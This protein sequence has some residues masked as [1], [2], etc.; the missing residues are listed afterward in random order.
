MDPIIRVMFR[1][2]PGELQRNYVHSLKKFAMDGDSAGPVIQLYTKLVTLDCKEKIISLSR[3]R[4]FYEFPSRS[5]TRMW[6]DIASDTP[7]ICTSL[8]SLKCIT[9][10]DAYYNAILSEINP[11]SG[12]HKRFRCPWTARFVIPFN[13]IAP[14][15][16]VV[17][18]AFLI[19]PACSGL[20]KIRL[21]TNFERAIVY[22][23][24]RQVY[25]ICSDG[26]L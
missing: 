17:I 12:R 15:G 7:D 26:H 9:S 8:R 20:S 18:I 11:C 3:H 5:A 23:L 1:A 22:R 21:S 2:L 19:A 6:H 16:P 14:D 4:D 10:S 25:E 24:Q 13:I